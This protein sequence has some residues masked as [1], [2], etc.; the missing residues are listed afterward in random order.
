M[1]LLKIFSPENIAIDGVMGLLVTFSI[2]VISGVLF[3]PF[4]VPAVSQN[5][6]L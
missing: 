1:E 5:S 3:A 6:A 4:V 2:V